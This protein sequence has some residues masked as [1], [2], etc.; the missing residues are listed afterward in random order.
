MLAFTPHLATLAVFCSLLAVT[1]LP[2][3]TIAAA[4]AEHEAFFYPVDLNGFDRNIIGG[5]KRQMFER[6]GERNDEL[7]VAGTI[8][9][10]VS[11][12]HMFG[13]LILGLTG[14]FR[15]QWVATLLSSPLTAIP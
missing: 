15:A 12:R 2:A 10:Q 1:M 13:N 4:V 5:G 6:D 3:S 9:V 11:H 8:Q 7:G 14:H